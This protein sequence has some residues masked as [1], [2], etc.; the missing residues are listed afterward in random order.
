[1][2]DGGRLESITPTPAEPPEDET[3]PPEDET[4][5]NETGALLADARRELRRWGGRLAR[6]I[7]GLAEEEDARRG[8]ARPRRPH[9]PPAPIAGSLALAKGVQ[10]LASAKLRAE[11]ERDEARATV[12][13]LEQ[14]IQD[15]QVPWYTRPRMEKL[16][17][18]KRQA[19]RERD[20]AR[21][22]AAKL[23]E[24]VK[25]AE[26][27]NQQLKEE[28]ER[29]LQEFKTFGASASAQPVA[30][31]D[32]GQPIETVVDVV[33]AAAKLSRL[34]FLKSARESAMKS[35]YERPED[36]YQAFRHL[37]RIASLR[38]TASIGKSVADWLADMG[39]T[40]APRLGQEADMAK[41]RS[42]YEFR[43]N[44]ERMLMEEHLKFGIGMDPHHC[45]RV[46]MKWHEGEWVIGHVGRHL[47]NAKT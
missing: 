23:E 44:G 11:R 45:L 28:N 12:A 47:E 3:E 22:E 19:E 4:D 24:T 1:M 31:A 33:E 15:D 20:E 18:G 37:S 41:F 14:T 42:N 9:T 7:V 39:V 46:Y 38:L 10:A 8:R 36:V 43:I 16:K 25:G 29:I 21:A 6:V 40:Y 5:M 2:V 34:R 26:L 30:G 27:A 13:K 17:D 32:A 35:P